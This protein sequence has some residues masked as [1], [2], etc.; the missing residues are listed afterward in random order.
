MSLL[1]VLVTES[2]LT[3]SARPRA[4][5]FRLV[6]RERDVARHGVK[7]GARSSP[8][9]RRWPRWNCRPNRRL[10]RRTRVS[11][12]RRL[13]ASSSETT[14]VTSPQLSTASAWTKA[15]GRRNTPCLQG[16][17]CEHRGGRR[18]SRR[19][20]WSRRHSRTR[21]TLRTFESLGTPRHQVGHRGTGSVEHRG[22]RVGGFRKRRRNV[23]LAD[24]G[25]VLG[26]EGE[27]RGS[28]ST[29]FTRNWPVAAFP[30]WSK[31]VAV[32]NK[33]NTLPSRA[34]S[35]GFARPKPRRNRGPRLTQHRQTP[36][37]VAGD[38]NVVFGEVEL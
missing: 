29:L 38:L 25:E 7:R 34:P 11:L 16:H 32:P 1:C 21:R 3:T 12:P 23:V 28:L 37:R 8:S 24:E 22:T 6:A 4:S 14:M 27:L 20:A 35:P 36:I 18:P 30:H 13:P 19:F 5:R 9:A 31:A 15:E 26:H 17:K 2:S 33:E 10:R